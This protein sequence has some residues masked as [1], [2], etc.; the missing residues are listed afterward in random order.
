MGVMCCFVAVGNLDEVQPQAPMA[1]II[2]IPADFVVGA[3]GA[4]CSTE[5]TDVVNGY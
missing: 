3:A 5:G 4:G 2:I 1:D